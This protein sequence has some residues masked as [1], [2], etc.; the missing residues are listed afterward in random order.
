MTIADAI[1]DAARLHGVRPAFA[2][3]SGEVTFRDVDDSTRGLCAF[4]NNRGAKKNERVG[5]LLPR[6]VDAVL[7]Y[8]GAM[9]AGL[10]VFPM[11]AAMFERENHPALDLLR[12]RFVFCEDDVSGKIA[13]KTRDCSWPC[14]VMVWSA[15]REAAGAAAGQA[16][17]P[18][19]VAPGD[20]VYYN[21]TSGTS[22]APKFAAT[23]HRHL[24]RNT[25]AVLSFFDANPDDVYLCLF[26]IDLHPH[27]HFMRSIMT[28]CK[29][30]LVESRHPRIIMDMIGRHGVTWLKAA[31]VMLDLLSAHNSRRGG[32]PVPLRWIEISG[33]TC[34]EQL[35]AWKNCFKGT[36]CRVWGS[37]ETTGVAFC[38][39]EEGLAD[40]T[41]LGPALTGYEAEILD[42]CDA[43]A[44]AGVMGRLAVGGEALFAG[45]LADASGALIPRSS[46]LHDT[47]DLA[48]RDRAGN[49]YFRGRA[50]GILKIA[51]RKVFIGAIENVLRN[52]AGIREAAVV[53]EADRKRE[54]IAIAFVSL[55]E[56]SNLDEA[57]ILKL[58]RKQDASI[59]APDRVSVLK[60][61][62]LTTGGKPDY[63][64]LSPLRGP[65][66]KQ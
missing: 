19:G 46:N 45:Y 5:V 4:L 9:R 37:T 10:A 66:N 52:I 41:L 21:M 26:P 27:E 12:P 43:K 8:L 20:I 28:G 15:F 53:G 33:V 65:A 54:D 51:G 40:N 18:G 13:A 6:S 11:N 42:E 7:A 14:E 57:D 47:G 55:S 56:G 16:D 38:C 3:E 24:V 49:F 35:G 23:S 64:R 25:E 39:D 50:R 34:A 31:P 59:P 63:S 48:C 2:D 61:L 30:L 29:T 32:K 36:M 44:G 60:R 1:R 58:F 17:E 22:G 62:P